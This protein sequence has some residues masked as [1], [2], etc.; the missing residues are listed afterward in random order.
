MRT[1]ELARSAG[2]KPPT[3]RYYERRGLLPTPA[4]TGSGYRSY[5]P[6]AVRIVRFVKR[7][8]QLGFTLAEVATLLELAAGGPDPCS[9]AQAVATAKIADLDSKIVQLTAMRAAL[10]RLLDTCASPRDDRDC[11]LLHALDD[12]PEGDGLP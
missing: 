4:R 7:A 3:L 8:Q 9:E 10:H 2:V 12:Q 11:P 5:G 1:I 6:D